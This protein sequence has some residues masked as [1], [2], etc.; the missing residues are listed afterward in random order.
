MSLALALTASEWLRGHIFTGFPWNLPAYGW[1]LSLAVLQ[2]A[3]LVGAY[4]LSLLTIL[5]GGSLAELAWRRWRLPAAM[6]LLFAAMWGFGAWRLAAAPMD[7]VPGVSIRL[8]QP[9]IPQA[10]KYVRRF[11]LRQ[12]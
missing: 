7:T 2:S 1:G 3:S 8:V 12:L 4:G 9:N 10:E 5:L 11:R 6:L